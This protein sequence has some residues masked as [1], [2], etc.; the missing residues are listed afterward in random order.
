MQVFFI[1]ALF[2]T[3]CAW[4]LNCFNTKK[5]SRSEKWKSTPAFK[6]MSSL[7]RMKCA[8]ALHSMV[9]FPVISLAHLVTVTLC[10][11][12]LNFFGFSLPVFCFV[13]SGALQHLGLSVTTPSAESIFFGQILIV[14]DEFA[15]WLS[16]SA[17]KRDWKNE[18]SSIN[19]MNAKSQDFHFCLDVLDCS[20]KSLTNRCAMRSWND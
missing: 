19:S 3:V 15:R 18:I 14:K 13:A 9:R 16:A 1:R 20:H 5:I 7:F 17:R 10:W 11:E 4:I 8:T 2:T 6:N 12:Q